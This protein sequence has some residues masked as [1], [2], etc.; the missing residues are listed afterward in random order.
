M[1][2]PRRT[3]ESVALAA[4]LAL[5]A[6][7]IESYSV[8]ILG[9]FAGAQTGNVVLGAGDAARL[10]WSSTAR[11]AWPILGFIGGV[12]FA[13]TLLLPSVAT[14]VRRPYR[15]L[16]ALELAAIIVIG[17]LPA[18]SPALLA[19]ILL[20]VTVAAQAS[21]FR[22]LVDV[23]YNSA[24]TTGNLMNFLSAAHAAVIGHQPIDRVH[25]R[26]IGLVIVCYVVGAVIGALGS[27]HW[28]RHG[29]WWAAVFLAVAIG[30]FVY[31]ERRDR[32]TVPE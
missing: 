29:A 30:V 4:V 6:G 12:L 24:F 26:R 25:A 28:H 17:A 8:I 7:A 18:S 10:D 9:A 20:T 2:A 11:Y 23:G 31:D 27:L 22:K 1:S 3:S 15:A 19:S 21:T 32:Q 13:Q 16:L 14:L 5:A